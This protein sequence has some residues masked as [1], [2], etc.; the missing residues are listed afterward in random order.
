MS[1]VVMNW[2]K[3]CRRYVDLCKIVQQPGWHRVD[4]V[5][6]MVFAR[7]AISYHNQLKQVAAECHITRSLLE[8]TRA[9]YEIL[10]PVDLERCSK[11]DVLQGNIR[12]LL[13]NMT[14]LQLTHQQTFDWYQHQ[15]RTLNQLE[16]RHRSRFKFRSTLTK[17]S[18]A[19]SLKPQNL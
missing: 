13:N 5:Q 17:S 12:G 9:Q 8:K 11:I 16:G 4:R 15:R 1:I 6:Q 14:V 19:A 2:L 3:V 7:R 18:A 10:K